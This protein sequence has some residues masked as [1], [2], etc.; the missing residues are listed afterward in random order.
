MLTGI[1]VAVAVMVSSI[2]AAV[3]ALLAVGLFGRPL[4][5][6]LTLADVAP[7]LEEAVFLFDDQIL[8]D[9]TVPARALLA[10]APMRGSDWGQLLAYLAPRFPKLGEQMAMLADRGLVEIEATGAAPLRLRAEFVSG[11]ARITLTDPSAEGQGV[12]VDGLSQRALEDEIESLR[13]TV[14]GAPILVWRQDDGG[15]VIWANRAYLLLTGALA[16]EAELTWP[17]PALFALNP[18]AITGGWPKRIRVAR[19]LAGGAKWFECHYRPISG[20]SLHYALPADAAVQ[21]E[22]SLREFV[23]TLTKTFADLPIGL[24]V[25]DRNRQLALFNPALLDLTTLTPDFLIARPTLFAV[26]DRLREA[27]MMPER[28]DY[29]TWRRHMADLEKAATSGLFEET[30]ALPNGQTYKVTGR[31]HPEGAVAFLIEDISAEVMLTRRFRAELEM[32]QAVIDVMDE[33]VAVFS[34]SGSLRLSNV[35]Y[36]GLWGSDPELTVRDV[37][38]AEAMKVWQVQGRPS[39][40]WAEARDFVTEM[41]QRTGW[42][43]QAEMRD[44]RD[45]VC[46]VVPLPGGAT[47]VGFRLANGA[48]L[49]HRFAPGSD[50]SMISPAARLAAREP[51]AT[52]R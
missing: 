42:T 3:I 43:G 30:W 25:F 24:A 15:A 6:T 33:A 37:G 51:T 52:G 31:P 16:G 48:P 45:V 28:K 18:A 35:A 4:R 9:A 26:L 2:A 8:V 13:A 12:L 39:P 27:R 47:L 34:P 14:D 41:G 44:G 40:V 38:I 7:P 23:Q 36:R 20:G 21:A 46:R 22:V 49:R 29:S 1:M 11:L 32:S 10:A 17:L 5:Q 19:P 50:S